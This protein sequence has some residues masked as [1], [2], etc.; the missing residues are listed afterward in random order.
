[1]MIKYDHKDLKEVICQSL[2]GKNIFQTPTKTVDVLEE[3]QATYDQTCE[4]CLD[5]QVY[6]DHISQKDWIQESKVDTIREQEVI[7]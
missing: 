5:Q 7:A 1:M 6:N 3:E 4:D 2:H